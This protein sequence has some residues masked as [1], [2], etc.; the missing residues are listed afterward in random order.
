MENH[1]EAHDGETDSWTIL[2]VRW[3]GTAVLGGICHRQASAI[4]HFDLAPFPEPTGRRLFLQLPTGAAGRLFEEFF[5]KTCTRLTISAGVWRTRSQSTCRTV[6]QQ[7]RYR[8]P[9][10]MIGIEHL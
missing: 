3:K 1:D 4:N 10:G 8:L 7:P 5:W 2:L 9:T 6:S